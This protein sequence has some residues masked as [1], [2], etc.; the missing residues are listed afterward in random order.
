MRLLVFIIML[1]FASAALAQGGGSVQGQ[2]MDPTGAVIPN[3]SV[4]LSP[5]SGQPATGTSD[6]LGRFQFNSVTPGTYT[7]HVSAKNFSQFTSRVTVPAGK[8]VS[9]NPK[10]KIQVEQQ[11]IDVEEPENSLDVA[12]ENNASALIL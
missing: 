5:S 6:G 12:P 8:V 10:L 2:V 9:I 7:I 1:G 4:V 11:K 3:A